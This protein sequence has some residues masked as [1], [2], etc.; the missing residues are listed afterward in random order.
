[1]MIFFFFC[2]KWDD[3]HLP[4]INFYIYHLFQCLDQIKHDQRFCIPNPKDSRVFLFTYLNGKQN[5]Q[6]NKV[7]TTVD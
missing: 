5:W 1:M 6:K 3:D 4:F 2:R 7:S